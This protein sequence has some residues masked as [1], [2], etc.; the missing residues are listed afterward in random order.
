M[1]LYRFSPI[2]DQKQ[3][4]SAIRHIHFECFKL[5]CKALGRYLPVAGNI[6]VFCHYDDE[7]QY[8][9]SLRQQL[10]DSSDNFRQKYFKLHA[11]IVIPAKGEIPETTYTYLYI[12]QPDPYRAQVGDVDFVLDVHE[13]DTLK[14]SLLAGK[15]LKGARAYKSSELDMIELH[16]PDVDALGYISTQTMTERVRVRQTS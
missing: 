9:T 1:K 6:G 10:T 16:D 8:L 15:M 11:P 3:L 12:R 13:Y 4:E 7:Y 2:R 5:C 14:Q